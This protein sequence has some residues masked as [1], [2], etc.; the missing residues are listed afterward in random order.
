MLV[1]EQCG[2]KNIEIRAWVDANLSLYHSEGCNEW[3][4][5]WC[6]DCEEHVNFI[7]EEEYLQLNGNEQSEEVYED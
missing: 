7:E 5:R 4:D 3:N 1:C 2:G 6:S